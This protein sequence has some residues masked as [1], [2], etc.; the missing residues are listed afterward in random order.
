MAP[1]P[2]RCP[3]CHGAGE[4]AVASGRIYSVD[5]LR[6]PVYSEVVKCSMCGG[7]GVVHNHVPLESITPRV[8]RGYDG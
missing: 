2:N 6:C 8:N 7:S 4:I 3:K 1:H 5:D